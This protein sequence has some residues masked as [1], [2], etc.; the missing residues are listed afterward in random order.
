MAKKKVTVMW[1]S[2]DKLPALPL[3]LLDIE[4]LSGYDR[5]VLQAVD[6]DEFVIQIM[7]NKNS[8]IMLVFDPHEKWVEDFS[9]TED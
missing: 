9:S 6:D 4:V 3:A 5:I 7:Q 2:I 8:L 1:R